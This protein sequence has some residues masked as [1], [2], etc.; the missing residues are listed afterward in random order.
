MITLWMTAIE[1]ATAS[2]VASLPEEVRPAAAPLT[3]KDRL[4][5]VAYYS[6]LAFELLLVAGV[7]VALF[8]M[9]LFSAFPAEFVQLLRVWK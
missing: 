2:V 7:P 9:I 6:I 5:G 1:A 4:S 3:W 8:L